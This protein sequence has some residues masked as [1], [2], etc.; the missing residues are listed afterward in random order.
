MKNR[1]QWRK[2]IVN[3]V[4]YQWC[5]HHKYY[6]AE[7]LINEKKKLF[8]CFHVSNDESPYNIPS[9]TPSF[10]RYCILNDDFDVNEKLK[11]WNVDRLRIE[12]LKRILED[13]E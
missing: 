10:I 8:K 11:T 4:E 7:I 5:F 9:I 2:I 6:S 13:D 1:K 3:D 12:K